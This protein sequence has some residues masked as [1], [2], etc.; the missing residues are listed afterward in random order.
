[1]DRGAGRTVCG[2]YRVGLHDGERV[3]DALWRPLPD[4]VG[5]GPLC[6]DPHARDG[7]G[8]GPITEWSK[9]RLVAPLSASFQVEGAAG[10][11]DVRVVKRGGFVNGGAME[12]WIPII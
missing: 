12:K 10:T 11:A 8:H 7:G 5:V 4:I 1:M 2:L 9:L 3:H 6:D